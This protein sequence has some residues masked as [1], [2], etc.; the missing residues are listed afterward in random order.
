MPR[1]ADKAVRI[2]R[3]HGVVVLTLRLRETPQLE[4]SEPPIG[5]LPDAIRVWSWIES[6]D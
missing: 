5:R 3:E 1:A 6:D 2:E 4:G